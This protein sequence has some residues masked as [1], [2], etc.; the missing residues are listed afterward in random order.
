MYHGDIHLGDTIDIKFCTVQSTGAPTT[1]SA[2]PVISAYVGNGT[3]ELTAGITLTVDFDSRTGMNNVRV[4][5]SSGNGYAAATNVQLVIT[6]GT[7][8]S[9]SAVGYVVGTFSID[10]RGVNQ[11]LG[12]AVSTPATAGVLDV[13]VKN[14]NNVAATS[15]TTIKAVQGLATDGVVPT[16]T[17]V[18]NQ[19]TAAAIATGIWQ[20]TTAGDFTT[21]LSVGKSI[22]NGVSLGTGLTIAT[23]TNV[24][25][26]NGLAANVIT[27]ASI[28]AAALNGKGDWNTTTPPTSAAI[29]TAV[30]TDTTA[31]DFTTALSVGKSVMNGVSLGTGLTI[32]AVSGA[33]GSVTGA[34]GSVTGAVGSVTGAV[35]SVTGNVGGNVAG[36]V[37]SVTAGVTVTTNNDKTGYALSATGSAAFTESYA[38]D[39]ATAT[40]PQLLYMTVALLSEFSISGTTLTTK[41]LDGSTS[42]GTFTLNSSTSPTSITRAT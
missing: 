20:D 35:G 24:T 28:N 9:V 16:V 10:C 23:A 25:T 17:T 36:S 14:M 41:Q 22:M 19:L 4:V 12:T 38:A 40:L 8:N 3:T 30:W 11:I 29:A 18:T 7:V 39:G 21:A 5:A 31:G 37:A 42:A 15:I 1:L 34:V 2:S 27:A 26:V 13:N 6:T 33:V 32:A